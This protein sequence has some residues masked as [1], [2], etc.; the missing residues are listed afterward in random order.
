MTVIRRR[1]VSVFETDS[2]NGKSKW[3]VR[4]CVTLESKHAATASS[5]K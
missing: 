3:R 5:A 1:V 4:N 2:E